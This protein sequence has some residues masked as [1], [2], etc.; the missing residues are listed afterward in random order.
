MTDTPVISFTVLFVQFSQSQSKSAS[1]IIK[2]IVWFSN[3]FPEDVFNALV[4]TSNEIRGIKLYQQICLKMKLTKMAETPHLVKA[5]VY[6]EVY[7]QNIA[8]VCCPPR[9]VTKDRL[10]YSIK[11]QGYCCRDNFINDVRYSSLTRTLI[12]QNLIWSELRFLKKSVQ[13]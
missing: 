6:D 2:A 5:L 13:V 10:V 9:H 12:I 4:N 8:E 3:E 7:C 1:N 11:Y